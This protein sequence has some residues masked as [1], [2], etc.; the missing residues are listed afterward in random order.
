MRETICCDYRRLI[1]E[2]KIFVNRVVAI[3]GTGLCAWADHTGGL[4]G[5]DHPRF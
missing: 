5:D 3:Y 4:C 2:K 1:S